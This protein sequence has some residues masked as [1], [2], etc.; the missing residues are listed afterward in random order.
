MGVLAKIFQKNEIETSS[1][2]SDLIYQF[3]NESQVASDQLLSAVE[4]VHSAMERLKYIADQSVS[5]GEG[6][7]ESSNKAMD[8]IQVLF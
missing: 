2:D 5:E 4:E 1:F 8:Q 7:K 6:L 3:I